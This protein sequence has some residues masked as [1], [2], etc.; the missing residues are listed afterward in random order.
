MRI[1]MPAWLVS[2]VLRFSFKKPYFNLVH[3]DGSAY[4]DRWWCMPH[5]CLETRQ[6]DNGPEL[7]PKRW[8]PFVIR[9]HR[10]VSSDNDRHLHD[11][12]FGNVSWLLRGG[13]WE[14]L[15]TSIDPTWEQ[16]GIAMR[17]QTRR[18]FRPEGSIVR[19]RA[20]DRHAIRILPNEQVFS[21][22]I[23]FRKCQPWGFY[24]PR[25]KVFWWDYATV[26]EASVDSD[27]PKRRMRTIAVGG[28]RV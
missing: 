24:T 5:W 8:L 25:G 6:T 21:L 26:L 11:H 12:P 15:P 10:I 16:H 2:R 4:M 28:A 27:L 13:Y 22:F 7:R 17:E 23:Q 9:V 20:T 3:A 1:R 18:V 19:R 14:I